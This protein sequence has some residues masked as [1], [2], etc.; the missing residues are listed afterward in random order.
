MNCSKEVYLK[1]R[2]AKIRVKLRAYF[3][4]PA[5]KHEKPFVALFSSFLKVHLLASILNGLI[6]RNAI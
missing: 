2:G 4:F 6:A 3:I 1:G 5:S